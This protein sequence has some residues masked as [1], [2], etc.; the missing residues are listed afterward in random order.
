MAGFREQGPACIAEPP[1]VDVGTMCLSTSPAPGVLGSAPAS[2]EFVVEAQAPHQATDVVNAFRSITVYGASEAT[3]NS[4]VR[5]L[6]YEP[7]A[8]NIADQAQQFVRT[9]QMTKAAAVEWVVA[10][11]NA[12]AVAVRDL[13]LTPLGRAISEMLK[14]RDALPNVAQQVTKYAR[15]GM[16]MER[17]FEAILEAGGRTRGSVN[18]LTFVLRRAGPAMLV[19]DVAFSAYLVRGAPEADRARVASREGGRLL[20][21]TSFGFAGFKVGCGVGGAAT[22]WLG[23]VSAAP[24]CLVGGLIVG[25]GSSVAGGE[26]GADA[27]EQYYEWGKAAIRWGDAASSPAELR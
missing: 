16:S 21:A 7:A 17:V 9:G 27:G 22:I 13:R 5:E 23:G 1:P 12:L 15:P 18:R 10:Q 11:R 19:A 20:G 26:L 3:W 4:F 2:R 8:Q 25:L 24:G 14:P 6:I